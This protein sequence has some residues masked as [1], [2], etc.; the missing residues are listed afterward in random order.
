MLLVKRD[1]TIHAV[2]Y[3]GVMAGDLVIAKVE[4]PY[5]IESET[6]EVTNKVLDAL[7]EYNQKVAEKSQEILKGPVF[8]PAP[9]PATPFDPNP[10]GIPH[11]QFPEYVGPKDWT[12]PSSPQCDKSYYAECDLPKSDTPTAEKTVKFSD[13]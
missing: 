10:W 4:F 9:L 13:R 2:A 5:G 12:P 6:V 7:D 1:E 8:I 11:K 3:D